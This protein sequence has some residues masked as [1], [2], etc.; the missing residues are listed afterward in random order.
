MVAKSTR[1]GLGFLA[2]I[3]AGILIG[4]MNGYFIGFLKVPPFVTTLGMMTF[5]SGLALWLT[6]GFPVQAM[7]PACSYLGS[8]Y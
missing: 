4:V 5:A 8:A 3:G 7:P 6:G 2:G 1:I